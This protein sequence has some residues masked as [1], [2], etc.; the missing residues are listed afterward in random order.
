LY[1]RSLVL[2]RKLGCAVVVA[3]M[4]GTSTACAPVELTYA[5]RPGFPTQVGPPRDYRDVEVLDREPP[6]WDYQVAGDFQEAERDAVPGG[7]ARE[8]LLMRWLAS[9]RG[10]D[11]VIVGGNVA[12][13]DGRYR[14]IGRSRRY[15]DRSPAGRWVA[16]FDHY[17]LHAECVV[18]ADGEGSVTLRRPEEGWVPTEYPVLR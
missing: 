2:G 16:V 15:A 10:C 6:S 5:P 1:R 9:Q 14:Y 18:R 17:G 7:R 13:F 12:S 3:S 8:A 11:G 4:L